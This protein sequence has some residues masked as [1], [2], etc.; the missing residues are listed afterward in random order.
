MTKGGQYTGNISNPFD[1]VAL[2]ANND[3]VSY[4]QYFAE[5]TH[6]FT[7]RGASNGDNMARVDLVIG[8]QT[9][10]TFY[11]GDANVAEYKPIGP[12]PIIMISSICFSLSLLVI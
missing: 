2:Y 10:G 4:T 6:D 7:L 3:E 12:A 11:F 1:G 8:N 5:G 9:K